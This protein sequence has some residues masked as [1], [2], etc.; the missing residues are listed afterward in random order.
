[1]TCLR[2]TLLLICA[3]ALLAGCAQD[4]SG[5]TAP[6]Q[7]AALDR[8]LIFPNP[9]LQ[10]DGSFQLAQAEYANAYYAAIDPTNLRTTLS[11]F[12]TVNSF[13]SGTGT[14]HLVVFRDTHD[15]GSG[16]RMIGRRNTDG[17]LAFL[18]ENY[19]VDAGTGLYTSIN[20]DAAVAQDRRWLIGYNGIEFSPLSGPPTAN[21]GNCVVKFYNFDPVSAVR[22]VMVDLDTR[23]RK[24]MPTIC[25]TC[26]G[27]RGDP[28]KA[29]GSF[30]RS[31]TSLTQVGNTQ[32][33]LHAFDVGSFDYS[34]QPGFTRAD[35]EAKL[36][37]FN[38]WVL[39]SYPMSAGDPGFNTGINTCRAAATPNEWWSAGAANMIKVWYGGTEGSTAALGASFVG[40]HI[41]SDWT[42]AGK[43][44]LW[45]QVVG[46]YCRTCHIVRGT[47]NQ[48]EID[49]SFFDAGGG[50]GFETFKERTKAHVFDRGNM[51]L[52]LYVFLNFWNDTTAVNAL[53]DFLEDGT[54]FSGAVPVRTGGVIPSIG[55]PVANPGPD[56]RVNSGATLSAAGSV[57]ATTYQWSV[58]AC[59]APAAT[60]ANATAATTTLTWAAANGG[61]CILQLTVG[62]AAGQTSSKTV[63]LTKDSAIPASPKFV[64]V[65]AVLQNALNSCTACHTNALDPATTGGTPPI[66]YSDY[67]RGGTP[68]TGGDGTYF[69]NVAD[70]D[71]W[72]FKELRGRVNLT[73]PAA[74]PL[75]R[76]PTGNQH[77]GG[78]ILDLSAATA[79][80]VC[81]PYTT[82]G[83]FWQAQ[84]SILANWIL[85]GAQYN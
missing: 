57:F 84:Y 36:R 83:A 20:V 46:K 85:T 4:N 34:T 63:L 53:A 47:L 75:L 60:I 43:G 7:S 65:R 59:T 45:T 69:A 26:H 16:R 21:C 82:Y 58:Q 8:F 29:D 5:D 48:N 15:L 41:P 38:Q 11:A 70:D 54:T 33:R 25:I 81:G 17:T 80:A 42:T 52:S 27:G 68:G 67:N 40:N 37:D 10:D 18:V 9:Q 31:V 79:C 73:D 19:R 1:M 74:S 23:G 76:K 49:F 44:V 62:N 32:A 3:L 13:G 72:F 14:E 71:Y 50:F 64:D 28:L 24:A 66:F 12:R 51:P 56:R 2:P 30:P 55:R 22:E 35:Q 6:T 61:T 39:C 78:N 77:G